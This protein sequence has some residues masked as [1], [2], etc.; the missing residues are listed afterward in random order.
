[1]LRRPRTGDRRRL[2]AEYLTELR[3]R[4]IRACWWSCGLRRGFSTSSF[5]RSLFAFGRSLLPFG[6]GFGI[7]HIL[8]FLR[9]SGVDF[10]GE[11]AII[12]IDGYGH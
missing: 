4:W 1:M 2:F 12:L 9:S 7:G 6:I 3:F 10:R 11:H 5:R 8:E